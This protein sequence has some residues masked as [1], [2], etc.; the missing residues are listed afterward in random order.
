MKFK[1][2]IIAA[3]LASACNAQAQDIN[4]IPNLDLEEDTTG[5]AS[6][7]DIVKMQQEALSNKVVDKHYESV[8]KRRSFP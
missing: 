7:N 3:S 8:W 1:T 4:T 6:V 2:F 5:V